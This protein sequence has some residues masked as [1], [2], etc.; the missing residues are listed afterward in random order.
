MRRDR[1]ARSARDLVAPGLGDLP[2]AEGGGLR[3]DRRG[4]GPGPVLTDIRP[5]RPLVVPAPMQLPRW[6]VGN[7]EESRRATPAP[8]PG[9]TS[10]SAAL[11]QRHDSRRMMSAAQDRGRPGT[12]GT[13]VG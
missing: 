9:T 8:G 13:S 12:L 10:Q 1:R 5:V 6:R 4:G 7:D 11:A 2:R 3:P